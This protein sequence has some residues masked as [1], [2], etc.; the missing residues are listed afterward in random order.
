MK[1]IRFTLIGLFPL[2]AGS[3]MNYMVTMLPI[4]GNMFTII[5]MLFLAGWFAI[6]YSVG[7]MK[8]PLQLKLWSGLG[9]GILNYLLICHQMLFLGKWYGNIFGL[10]TQFYIMPSLRLVFIVNWLNLGSSPFL[11]TTAAT[12]I[13]FLVFIMGAFIAQNRTKNSFK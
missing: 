2:I 12:G 9:I 8:I 4:A 5:S 3:I 11:Y 7:K 1:I 6:G 10:L 13:L